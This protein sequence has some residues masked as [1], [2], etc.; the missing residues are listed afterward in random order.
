MMRRDM[1]KIEVITLFNANCLVIP[2]IKSVILLSTNATV[3]TTFSALRS[4]NA[5]FGV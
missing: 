1:R 5:S 3:S 2:T 4:R